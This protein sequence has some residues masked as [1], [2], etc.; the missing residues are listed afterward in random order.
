MYFRLGWPVAPREQVSL[1][2]SEG[3]FLLQSEDN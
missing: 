2:G 1:A 3:A